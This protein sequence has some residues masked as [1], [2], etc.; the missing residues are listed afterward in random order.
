[1]KESNSRC[2]TVTE[3]RK[4]SIGTNLEGFTTNLNVL[5]GLNEKE[6]I[7][8]KG[9][10]R[11]RRRE[12][13]SVAGSMDIELDSVDGPQ[14]MD[15]NQETNISNKDLSVSSQST[16]ATLARQDSHSQ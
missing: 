7:G 13:P 10:E 8:L 16:L 1:M 9:D 12:N 5:Y 3:S 6:V 14:K 4:N 2:L 15:T 11:K